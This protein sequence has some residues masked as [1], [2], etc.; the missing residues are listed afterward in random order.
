MCPQLI[1]TAEKFNPPSHRRCWSEVPCSYV[2]WIPYYTETTLQSLRYTIFVKT[3]ASCK[4]DLARL[5]PTEDACNIPCLQ[6]LPHLN[7]VRGRKGCHSMGMEGSRSRAHPNNN[8]D[9]SVTSSLL[10][11]LSCG[12]KKGCGG[13]GCPYLKAGL[14]CSALCKFFPSVSCQNVSTFQMVEVGEDDDVKPICQTELS[15]LEPLTKWR[16]WHSL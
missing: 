10:K 1:T 9:R 12:C 3:A 7:L 13:S 2:W 8:D 16:K 6:N 4:V 11:F 14:K 5:P 15:T